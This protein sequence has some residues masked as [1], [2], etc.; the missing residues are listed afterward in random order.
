ML[1]YHL[2]DV[3]LEAD[4]ENCTGGRFTQALNRAMLHANGP[5][6]TVEFARYTGEWDAPKVKERLELDLE[7][8]VDGCGK[9]YLTAVLEVIEEEMQNLRRHREYVEN[10]LEI[11]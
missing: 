5:T 1:R 4:V 11:L 7:E 6:V 9:E 3:R 8:V 10:L 2:L